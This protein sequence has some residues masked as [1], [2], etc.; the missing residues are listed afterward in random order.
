MRV[1]VRDNAGEEERG[2]RFLRFDFEEIRKL[3][4]VIV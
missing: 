3:A 4:K 1:S 2:W